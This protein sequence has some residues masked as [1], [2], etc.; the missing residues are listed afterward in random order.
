MNF[1]DQISRYLQQKISHE[2]YDNWLRE[3]SLVA[4]DGDTLYVSTP[5]RQTR[6]WLETEYSQLIRNAIRELGLTIRRVSFEN[7]VPTG[8]T[9]QALAAVESTP[10]GESR[11]AALN[12]KF[13]FG[14]FVVG[15]CNQFAAAAA[16]SVAENPSRSY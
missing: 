11:M 3:T 7:Q 12:P 4:G 13:T 1:W 10:D 5:D 15:A 16:K 8:V 2:S 9:N 6:T 14:T